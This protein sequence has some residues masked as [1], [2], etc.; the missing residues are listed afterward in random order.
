MSSN[1]SQAA[2]A[3]LQDDVRP[4]PA[5]W[6]LVIGFF[7]ILVDSTIVSVATPAIM[8]GLGAGIDSVIWVTSAYLLAYAVPL[9]VT[10]RLGDRFGPKRVYLVG[11]VVFTLSSAWCGLSGTV[12]A[13][14]IA[15]VLQ[16][17]GAAL[18][19][20]QTMSVITRIF[21]PERRGAAMGLWGS[22]AGVATLVGPVLGGVLVDSA[23]WE[24]IFF[25][26]VPVGV[27]GFILAARLVPTLPTTSHRFDMLGVFL[28]AAGLFC[29]VF[30]IQEG[31]S[32][33]WGTIAGPLSVWS[34]IITG[35]LLL[36]AFVA[37]QRF[38]RGEPLIPLK[39][40]RD[41]NFSLANTSI[42]AMGFSI[43]TMSLPLMLYAQTVRGLSPTQAAL[44]LTPMAVISGVLAPFVGKYVQRSN[45]KYIAIAGFAAMSVALFWMGSILTPDVPIWQL[46]LPISL[47]GLSS[48]GI[49]APVSLT[50]TRNL[51]PSLA[52]AGSGVY[53]TTRQMGAVLGSAAVAAVM[54][55]RLMA[56]LGGGGISAT[57]G[58]ALP[59]EAKAGYALSMGQS[60]YLPA[61]VI[62][63]GFAAA[64]FFARPQ[65]NRAWE[66][67]AGAVR[68]PG[69][70][71]ASSD[72]QRE[73]TAADS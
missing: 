5:L 28:S 8:E 45:P 67:D 49:W 30:G 21:P 13:L 43:T 33:D 51:A 6:S 16:G 62:I 7:M 12:E 63:V 44:L 57:P 60:L 73:A 2:P 14:I 25:I 52:G 36:V 19:T 46:L 18:M 64:L 34:L 40:F 59:E 71:P 47:L 61:S 22:V 20:P 1:P 39:L 38:N 53:N 58:T 27:V 4:W 11:L 37:W 50:A 29:L 3:P 35:I 54:Q 66:R 23:G 41:R 17:L 15:R 55:S 42:T 72:R 56:N 9:L 68:G 26:N 10:G 65:Q 69:A 48:A 32:Y 70:H 24:W 31:E